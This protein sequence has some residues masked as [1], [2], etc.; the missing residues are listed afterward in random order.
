MVNSDFQADSKIQNGQMG[1]GGIKPHKALMWS[2]E[3]NAGGGPG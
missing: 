3:K 2:F 1:E